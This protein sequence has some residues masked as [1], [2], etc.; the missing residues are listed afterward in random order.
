[1][2]FKTYPDFLTN[3][4][5]KSRQILIKDSESIKFAFHALNVS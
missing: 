2:C 5:K 4:F 3:K 1:M